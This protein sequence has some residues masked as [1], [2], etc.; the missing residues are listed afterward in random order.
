MIGSTQTTKGKKNKRTRKD[1]Y[2][3]GFDE[4]Y[5]LADLQASH[6]E[7]IEKI[8]KLVNDCEEAVLHEIEELKQEI[9][10]CKNK[11]RRMKKSLDAAYKLRLKKL[12]LLA[13]LERAAEGE[14][15]PRPEN[16]Y[17]NAFLNR[18]GTT[19]KA[20]EAVLAQKNIV[21]ISAILFALGDELRRRETN[22]IYLGWLNAKHPPVDGTGAVHTWEEFLGPEM[23]IQ[24]AICDQPGAVR[25]GCCAQVLYCGQECADAHWDAHKQQCIG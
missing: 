20:F 24:C 12:G 16:P 14:L 19:Q 5:N 22:E 7:K 1:Q 17:I 4:Y 2:Q 23:L 18:Y 8:E 3:F 13:D 15:K 9:E 6:K 11:G 10:D 25:S 21:N